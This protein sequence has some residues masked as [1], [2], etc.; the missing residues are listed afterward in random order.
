MKNGPDSHDAIAEP[1]QDTIE[2]VGIDPSF[3]ISH[4]VPVDGAP[5]VC[6]IFCDKKR[7]VR[8]LSWTR[9]HGAIVASRH[10]PAGNRPP[11]GESG[12]GWPFKYMNLIG[13]VE[14]TCSDRSDVEERLRSG[15][16]LSQCWILPL[17]SLNVR[18]LA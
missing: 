9:G 3:V 1:L 7:T 12:G 17:I 11:K 8:Q 15:L 4:L 14:P 18:E 2:K 13:S 16:S 6:K 10:R 5:E